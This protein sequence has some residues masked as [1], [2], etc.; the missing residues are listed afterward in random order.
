MR[1]EGGLLARTEPML[2]PTGLDGIQLP[3]S[4]GVHKTKV[5]M[6]TRWAPTSNLEEVRTLSADLKVVE[7]LTVRARSSPMMTRSSSSQLSW[8]HSTPHNTYLQRRAYGM[9]C[10]LPGPPGT[11]TNNK[12]CYLL[13]ISGLVSVLDYG[14]KLHI[15]THDQLP[16]HCCSEVN[17]TDNTEIVSSHHF[18]PSAYLL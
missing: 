14:P 9:G 5:L 4:N 11:T 18:L 3:S 16:C 1:S 8:R 7:S 6:H 2:K 10:L 12:T 15:T 13:V 17:I